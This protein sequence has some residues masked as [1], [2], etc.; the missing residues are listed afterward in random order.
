MTRRHQAQKLLQLQLELFRLR[1]SASWR[2]TAPFRQV[3]RWTAK[4]LPRLYGLYLYL[5][6]NGLVALWALIVKKAGIGAS[7]SE[8]LEPLVKMP[9]GHAYDILFLNGCP[10]GQSQ[11]YRIFN[12]IEMLKR[13]GHTAAVL[14][15][16][17][18]AGLFDMIPPKVVVL[19]RAD[20]RDVD[21]VV[22]LG[23]WAEINNV[24]IVYDI[25]D[26]IF[27]PDYLSAISAYKNLSRLEKGHFVRGLFA[28]KSLILKSDLATTSTPVLARLIRE[29]GVDATCIPNT[30]NMAQLAQ[31]EAL[32]RNQVDRRGFRIGYFSGSKTH[33]ADF[34]IVTPALVTMLK[35]YAD[36][37]LVIVGHLNLPNSLDKFSSQIDRVGIVDP[38]ELMR[39][40][41]TC[42]VTIA[43]LEA[44]NIFCES[45][46]ELKYFESA[47]V[48]VPLIASSTEIYKQII[49]LNENGYLAES[50]NDWFRYLELLYKDRDLLARVG[51]RAREHALKHYG[52]D[53][54]LK[55]YAAI[56]R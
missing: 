16:A 49:T 45:K 39:I 40:N 18:R 21:W 3:L 19:F 14:P 46:S 11:R 25:D 30:L 36:A 42:H 27:E 7:P 5:S 8:S 51:K 4:Y 22:R 13:H 48:E 53:S 23:E 55:A 17:Q 50:E 20:I 15:I 47:I 41:H 6:E 24:R 26:L 54:A 56:L 37:R 43:P 35:K 2:F 28:R 29:M 1:A 12:P 34:A 33:E 38:L 9:S 32:L 52:P 31:A 10:I 44:D